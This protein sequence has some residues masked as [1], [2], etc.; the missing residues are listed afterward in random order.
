MEP[1]DETPP[2]EQPEAATEIVYGSPAPVDDP[3][4]FA[5]L[6]T[7][8]EHPAA[9]NLHLLP[10]RVRL[11]VAMLEAAAQELGVEFEGRYVISQFMESKHKQQLLSHMFTREDEELHGLKGVDVQKVKS[12][13]KAVCAI[14]GPICEVVNAV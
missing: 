6:F 3:D 11:R 14:V 9:F 1:T 12:V 2:A 5:D 4:G 8:T 10:K 13:M 7:G